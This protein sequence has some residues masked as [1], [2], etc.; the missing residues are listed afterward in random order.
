VT[1]R[2]FRRAG[3]SNPL[4]IAPDAEKAMEYLFGNG[5][6]SEHKP[7][8]PQLI[9]LDLH[10][11]GMSGIEFLRAV[12]GYPSTRHIPVVV[13]TAS[14]SD[15]MIKECGRLGADTYIVKPLGLGSL[16]RATPN[17]SLR[18]VQRQPV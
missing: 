12:K 6:Q 18:L 15:Q 3:I 17:L 2:V 5:Q 11:P 8:R 13:L 14:Q 10:L 9:L 1:M 16:V 7:G 4:K